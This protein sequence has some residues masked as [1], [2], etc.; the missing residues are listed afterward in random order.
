MVTTPGPSRLQEY[1][2][3]AEQAVRAYCGWHVAPILEESL[4]LDGSGTNT[5]FIPSLRVV[6]VTAINNGGQELD[7]ATL[8]WS[9][10]GYARLPEYQTWTDRLRGVT[11]QLRHGHGAAPDIVEIIR[12]M[13]ARA[14][15]A[16]DTIAREGA[17][18]VFQQA[19]MVAPNVAGGVVLMAHEREMLEP[20]RL[21]P[22]G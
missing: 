20:Y 9:A 21:R 15:S 6:S 17:N 12:A 2:A 19:S 4:T 14:A 13:A 5:L 22:V 16:P 7:P 10:D 8:E 18:G 1:L 11:L 3:G